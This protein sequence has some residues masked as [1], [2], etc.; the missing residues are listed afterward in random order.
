MN[1][2]RKRYAQDEAIAEAN[3]IIPRFTQHANMTPTKYGKAL[4]AE[5]IRARD[6]YDKGPLNDTFIAGVDESIHH[7]LHGYWAIHP[8]ADPNDPT[9]QAQ[10]FLA[11]HGSSTKRN[12]TPASPDRSR[13]QQWGKSKV[14]VIDSD[15]LST[16]SRSRKH[17]NR[18]Q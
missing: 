10:S 3:V 9:L 2:L 15:S 13:H 11:V 5:A 18:S 12:Q 7:C 4:F 16:R 14:N 17:R 8:Q 6:V 1:H